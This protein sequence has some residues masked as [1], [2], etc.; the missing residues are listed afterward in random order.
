MHF[1]PLVVLPVY[2]QSMLHLVKTKY[3]TY[4]WHPRSR[5]LSRSCNE[6]I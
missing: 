1:S 6:I 3:Y 5:N 2:R 4:R